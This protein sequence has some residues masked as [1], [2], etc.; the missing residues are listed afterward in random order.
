MTDRC[1]D[2]E[3]GV[4]RFR[5]IGLVCVEKVKTIFET[6]Y[7]SYRMGSLTR[8]TEDQV[9][10]LFHYL[11]TPPGTAPPPL[12]GRRCP[13]HFELPD[14]GPV[15]MK[16][17]YRGG[18]IR[19]LI[20]QTHVKWGPTRPQA[21]FAMLG[22]VR[23]I[24]IN[25]PE[26]VVHITYGNWLYQGWLVMRKIENVRPMYELEDTDQ[27]ILQAAVQNLGQQ[28]SR[29]IEHH[30]LHT[31]LHPGNVLLDPTGKTYIVDF[32]KTRIDIH[33]HEKLKVHY[34]NR[35]QRA[36]KKHQLPEWLDT[37]MTDSF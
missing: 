22:R 28:I 4:I 27:T 7:Q 24:G 6:I 8:L 29:L 30:I 16:K 26:P 18:F 10:M 31:D 15:T 9:A 32:D 11:N 2:A 13:T 23:K 35:W 36:I 12:S 5:P 14:Y 3:F 25:A 34:K 17:Y 33:N 21:E 1:Q 19:H 20:R 37:I